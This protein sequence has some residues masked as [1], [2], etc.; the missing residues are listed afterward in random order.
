MAG[1]LIIIPGGIWIWLRSLNPPMNGEFELEGLQKP[2]EVFFDEYGVPHIY[3]ENEEDAYYALGYCVARDRW[4]QM[5]IVR[6]VASGRLAE[7]IGKDGIES[8]KLYRTLGLR[9]Y[10][11]ISAKSYLG[12]RKSPFQKAAYAYLDGFNAY[13]R[14]GDKPFEFYLLGI[15]PEEITPVDVYT[16]VGYMAFGFA[17]GFREDPFNTVVL[18]QLGPGYLADLNTGWH[19]D[20]AKIPVHR[21]QER[22]PG[23]EMAVFNNKIIRQHIAPKWIGSNGWAMSGSRTKS[24]KPILASDTHMG[25]SQPSIWYEAHMEF[26]GHSFYGNFLPGV[27]A[28]MVGHNSFSGWGLTMFENDDTDFYTEIINPENPSECR[29]KGEWTKLE[30]RKEKIKVKDGENLDIEVRTT[31]HGPIISD[32]LDTAFS[33]KGKTPVSVWWTFHKEPNKALEAAWML[34]HAKGLKDAVRAASMINAPGLNAQYADIHGNIAWWATAKLVKRAPHVNPKVFLDGSEGKDEPE[35]YY[36]FE[37]NPHSVNPPW[38]FIYSA[39]NQ[40]DSIDGILYPGYYVPQDRAARIEKLLTPGNDW[41]IEKMQEVITDVVSDQ[42]AV[43]AQIMLDP[44]RDS[45]E[46]PFGKELRD[47]LNNWK[48]S[49]RLTDKEPIVFYKYLYHILHEGMSDELGEGLFE[50]FNNSHLMQRSWPLLL[51]ND[52]SAWWDDIQTAVVESKWDIFNRAWTKSKAELKEQLGTDVKQWEWGQVHYLEFIHPI[53]RVRPFDKIL[54]SGRV[55]ASGG[56]ETINNISFDLNGSGEYRA[57]FGPAMR[58]LIDFS[59]VRNSVSVL[60]AGQSGYFMN[61]HYR[62]Q[63]EMYSRGGFR[64]QKM[65][66]REIRDGAEGRLVLR[67]AGR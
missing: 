25:Y 67:P 45:E 62:D 43:S 66:E 51:N 13:V 39:N 55:P 15:E 49:H 9:H 12:E 38:G 59:D 24:G 3:A 10:G 56:S 5:E 1:L 48:G 18:N 50:V 4:F 52:S 14:S 17:E 33:L 23:A 42:K 30:V 41:D 40:P 27:P 32:V 26:P 46:D 11:E 34:L 31:P 57:T 28:A 7:T 60:P 21:Y 58:I 63:M 19:P 53:G 37:S 64:L 6:R 29:F 35:G 8:D 20:H 2:V 47:L 61:R 16:I 22:T 65:D 44:I 54:N 36:P